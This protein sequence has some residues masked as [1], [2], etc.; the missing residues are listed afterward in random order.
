MT[1]PASVV[2]WSL[3]LKEQGKMTTSS[4][5]APHQES[6]LQEHSELHK[7]CDSDDTAATRRL[8]VIHDN[9]IECVIII[10][11]D[12]SLDRKSTLLMTLQPQCSDSGTAEF[13]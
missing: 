9:S 10:D 8:R 12:C 6:V 2:N 7:V 13:W 3:C 4:A 11:T 5:Y 1:P